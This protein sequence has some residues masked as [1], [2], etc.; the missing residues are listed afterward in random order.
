M[1]VSM[2]ECL[3]A[4]ACELSELSVIIGIKCMRASVMYLL[5]LWS[6]SPSLALH[7]CAG[8]GCWCKLERRRILCMQ[9]L[10]S[11]SQWMTV[12]VSSN[13]AIMSRKITGT[14]DC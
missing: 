9:M 3:V 4:F 12:S 8:A 10:V 6:H 11:G 5:V 1:C 7:S 2:C 14:I 13:A